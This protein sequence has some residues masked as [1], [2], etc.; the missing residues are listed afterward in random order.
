MFQCKLQWPIFLSQCPWL[1]GRWPGYHE[2]LP[3]RRGDGKDWKRSPVS[4]LLHLSSL[5]SASCSA[6]GI[7]AHLS[8]LVPGGR[9]EGKVK[10]RHLESPFL[11]GAQ[12]RPAV[13][14]VL[15][16]CL[17]TCLSVPLTE[18]PKRAWALGLQSLG[19]KLQ[20]LHD[21]VIR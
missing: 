2:A 18:R 6:A 16:A 15:F 5:E 11:A 4:L 8:G 7:L 20:L 12:G 14:E 3:A 21:R 13:A 1:L 9:V 19:F 10:Q 17:P